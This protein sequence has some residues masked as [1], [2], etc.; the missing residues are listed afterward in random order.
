MDVY[1]Y[2]GTLGCSMESSYEDI[3]HAYYQRARQ[4]HPDKSIAAERDTSEFQRLAEAWSILKDPDTRKKYDIEC[5]QAELDSNNLVVHATVSLH[6]LQETDE[7]NIL[8]FPCRCGSY[9]KVDKQIL[10]EKNCSVY[11]TCEECTFIIIV[12]T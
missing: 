8:S 5:K 2:Y 3:K 9:Y 7:E 12:I 11:V 4:F 1:N 10:E 6:E